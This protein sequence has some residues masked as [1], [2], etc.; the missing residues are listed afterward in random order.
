MFDRFFPDLGMNPQTDKGLLGPLSDRLLVL[1]ANRLTAPASEHGFADWLR[2]YFACDSHGRRFVP[3]Y[4]SDAERQA[5]KTPR[6]RVQ[7]FQLQCWYRTLDALL[8]LKNRIEEHLFD[9]FQHLFA[10]QCDLVF[11]VRRPCWTSAWRWT[12][13]A[14]LLRIA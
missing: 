12:T 2:T 3:A 8:P 13:S 7:A 9:R 5:S 10:P 1:V 11:Y 14:T 6:V 4:R